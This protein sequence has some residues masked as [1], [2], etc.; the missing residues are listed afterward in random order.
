M[1]ECNYQAMD[2]EQRKKRANN[3]LQLRCRNQKD[4]R[5][6]CRFIL[7]EREGRQKVAKVR[8]CEISYRKNTKSEKRHFYVKKKK[9]FWQKKKKKDFGKGL[10][11]KWQKSDIVETLIEKLQNRKIATFC[12]DYRK[13]F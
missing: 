13:G 11:K 9:R 3:K 10:G 8:N 7:F 5:S 2:S 1:K 6:Q 12:P 4:K